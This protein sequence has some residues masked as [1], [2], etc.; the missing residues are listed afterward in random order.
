[1]NTTARIAVVAVALVTVGVI[2]CSRVG[3]G[4]ALP[5]DPALDAALRTVRA[6][7]PT[8]GAAKAQAG[9]TWIEAHGETSLTGFGVTLVHVKGPP[10][11]EEPIPHDVHASGRLDEPSLLFFQKTDGPQQEWPLIGVGYHRAFVPCA[12]P[13]LDDDGQSIAAD[14][15]YIHEAGWHHVPIG[16]GGFTPATAADVQDGVT[17]DEAGCTDLT[18]DDLRNSQPFFVAHGRAWTVHVWL[19]GGSCPVVAL[20]DPF[21]RTD[22]VQRGGCGGD[23]CEPSLDVVGRAFFQQGD[24][25]AVCG[26]P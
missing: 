26:G 24:C 4:C 19:D 21:G 6:K 13:V 18:A 11:L 8:F 9:R 25:S 12:P 5:C 23:V 20:T 1:M 17:F 7:T 3:V 10:S 2:D 22:C 16:D 14:S 15:W